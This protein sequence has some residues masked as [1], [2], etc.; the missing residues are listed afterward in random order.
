[1][2]AGAVVQREGRARC[3][4]RDE[5]GVAFTPACSDRRHQKAAFQLRACGLRRAHDARNIRRLRANYATRRELSAIIA[6]NEAISDTY[7]IARGWMGERMEL[8]ARGRAS[9]ARESRGGDNFWNARRASPRFTGKLE[10]R[11]GNKRWRRRERE[12]ERERERR[13]QKIKYLNVTL[14]KQ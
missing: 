7:L 6:A 2:Y 13:S 5:D 10:K 8:G 1:M 3:R 11:T 14:R 12:R 4:D 9:L